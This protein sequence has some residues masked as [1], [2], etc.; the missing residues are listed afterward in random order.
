MADK[1]KEKKKE[2]MRDN[3]KCFQAGNDCGEASL[4]PGLDPLQVPAEYRQSFAKTK[5][6]GIGY[7]ALQEWNILYT[8]HYY[9]NTERKKYDRS[10]RSNVPR[11]LKKYQSGFAFGFAVGAG[12][13]EEDCGQ[14]GNMLSY[15]RMRESMR[16]TWMV[17]TGGPYFHGK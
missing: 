3:C 16:L 1:D 15:T 4:L 14:K 5:I 13:A 7:K 2:F 12:F 6:P 9:P 11:S 8:S 10:Q 17:V